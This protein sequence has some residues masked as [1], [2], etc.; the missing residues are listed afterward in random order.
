MICALEGKSIAK[1]PTEGILESLP[2]TLHHGS[3]NLLVVVEV[4]RGKV[5]NVECLRLL[6]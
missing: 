5:L 1:E 3:L 4:A 2:V 6:L